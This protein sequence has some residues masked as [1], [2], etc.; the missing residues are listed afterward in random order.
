MTTEMTLHRSMALALASL[1]YWPELSHDVRRFA[2]ETVS[3][4]Q[5]LGLP[6]DRY[7]HFL[8]WLAQAAPARVA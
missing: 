5:R 1:D 2:Y 4:M 8:D 3:D 6:V 7:E